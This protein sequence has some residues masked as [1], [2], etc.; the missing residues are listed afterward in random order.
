MG[1]T[2]TLIV[3]ELSVLRVFTG[4]CGVSGSGSIGSVWEKVC[5]SGGVMTC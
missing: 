2:G 1:N 5:F 3:R 4:A